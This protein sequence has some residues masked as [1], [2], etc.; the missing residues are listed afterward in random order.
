MQTLCDSVMLTGNRHIPRTPGYIHLSTEHHIFNVV[1]CYFAEFIVVM[2]PVSFDP[3]QS[4]EWQLRQQAAL[5]HAF[6]A[7]LCVNYCN[8]CPLAVVL[9]K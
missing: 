6:R 9:S 2:N 5:I 1:L 3:I 8:I 7:H 4:D